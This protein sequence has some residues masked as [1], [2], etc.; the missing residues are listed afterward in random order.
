M[1]GSRGCGCSPQRCWRSGSC[2]GSTS[3]NLQLLGTC[4]G[5]RCLDCYRQCHTPRCD[6]PGE[7]LAAVN[8][9]VGG[10]GATMEGVGGAG[11]ER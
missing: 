4:R 5:A 9:R 11:D 10:V 2:V 8:S 6:G 1:E 3:R 7:S